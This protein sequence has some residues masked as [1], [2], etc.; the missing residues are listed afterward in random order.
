MWCWWSLYMGPAL[1]G[2]ICHQCNH[3]VLINTFLLTIGQVFLWEVSFGLWVLSLCVCASVRVCQW[4]ACLHD[5]WWP[6]QARITKFGP[7]VQNTFVK[8][9]MVF[10]RQLTLAPKVKFN[11]K[12]NFTQFWASSLSVWYPSPIQAKITKFGPE[13]QNNLVKVLGGNP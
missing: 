4:W 2:L 6:V 3:Y 5:N 11:L 7:K 13:V 12:S 8:A 9:H 1:Q 10:W